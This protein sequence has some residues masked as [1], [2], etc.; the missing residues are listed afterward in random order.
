MTKTINSLLLA[1]LFVSGS[2][3]AEWVKTA[4]NPNGDAYYI[5]PSTL[6][7]DVNLRR[8][9]SVIDLKKRDKGGDMSQ[10]VRFEFDCK[11]AT[12]RILSMST[13]S[14]AMAKGKTLLSFSVGDRDF[15]DAPPETPVFEIMKVVCAK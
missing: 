4:V 12:V 14:E 8:V 2:A 11:Q 7:K 15:A 10:R 3:W 13:H 5:D 9:W 6:G 1:L